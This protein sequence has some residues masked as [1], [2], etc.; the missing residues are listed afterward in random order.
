MIDQDY[1]LLTINKPLVT[2]EY[3]IDGSSYNMY[4]NYVKNPKGFVYD[5][6]LVLS[7]TPAF[8]TRVKYCIHYVADKILAGQSKSIISDSPC[9]LTTLLTLPVGIAWYLMIVKN[10]KTGKKIKI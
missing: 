10:Y 2:V 4:R 3:Q 8:K 7:T 5:T 6:K 1:E 9:K